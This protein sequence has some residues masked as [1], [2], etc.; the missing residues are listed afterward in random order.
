MSE[1]FYKFKPFNE[2]LIR[3]LCN[4]KIYYSPPESFNDPLDCSPTIEQDVHY[5]MLN[6][7]YHKIVSSQFGAEAAMQ[8]I[9]AIAC[10]LEQYDKPQPYRALREECMYDDILESLK[11][12]Y[13]NYGVLSLTKKFDSP[14]MWSHYADQ[15]RGLCIEY[16]VV[17]DSGVTPLKVDYHAPRS[18]SARKIFDWI[19]NNSDSV[20]NDIT[21][22]YFLSKAKEWE[23]ENEWRCISTSKGVDWCPFKISSIFFG[24][25]CDSSIVATIIKLMSSMENNISYF[26][27]EPAD[28]QFNLIK[29]AISAEGIKASTPRISALLAFEPFIL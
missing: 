17:D 16:S 24:M 18:I 15:H 19:K 20:D 6:E 1:L 3:E 14:L 22:R 23:Y 7:L 8:K 27:M 12:Y 29:T 25:R 5:E 13:C 11:K 2:Y 28:G 21:Q 9:Q 10:Q 26:R 4:G